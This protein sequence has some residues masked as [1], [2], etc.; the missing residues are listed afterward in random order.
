M[1]RCISLFLQL[2]DDGRLVATSTPSSSV[3]GITPE[4]AMVNAIFHN[5]DC[6]DAHFDDLEGD[7]DY[8]GPDAGK[9]CKKSCKIYS[10]TELTI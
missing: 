8:A 4:S 2:D 10:C 3:Y 6:W 5:P 1:H 9:Y 7:I